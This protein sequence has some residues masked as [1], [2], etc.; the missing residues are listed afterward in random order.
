MRLIF[1]FLS[2]KKI[3]TV[4]LSYTQFIFICIKP[5]FIT[6]IHKATRFINRQIL[7]KTLINDIKTVPRMQLLFLNYRMDSFVRTR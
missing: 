5:F 3:W 6:F 4:I 1:Y 2:F 7:K